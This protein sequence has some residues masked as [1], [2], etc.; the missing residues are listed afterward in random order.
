MRREKAF[1]VFLSLW[2]LIGHGIP[3]LCAWLF[4]LELWG[5]HATFTPT[6]FFSGFTA[7][8]E[9]ICPL[10][11]II[12]WRFKIFASVIATMFLLGAFTK[13]FPWLH[14][15][16]L[17]QGYAM[18]FA[19]IPSKEIYVIYALAYLSILFHKEPVKIFNHRMQL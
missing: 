11:I 18:D 10:L 8:I 3:K 2:L 14:E 15:K 12:G 1:R 16:V 19:I 7:L 4:N 9:F 5:P 17:V 13:P 6:N